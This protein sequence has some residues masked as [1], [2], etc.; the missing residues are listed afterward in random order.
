MEGYQMTS[1]VL[2]R[3]DH[4]KAFRDPCALYQD[5]IWWLYYT[6]V[7]TEEDGRV[8]LYT[9]MS[10]SANLREWSK[11]LLLTPRDQHL[12]FSSPG[13]V[14]RVNNRWRMCLQSYPRPNGEKY[15]NGDCRIWMMESEDLVNWTAPELL[16]VKG[17][18]VADKD[19]GRMIDPYFIENAAKPGEWFCFYKQNGVS[20]SKTDN[21]RQWTYCGNESAGEN[22]CIIRDEG[23]Y[24]MFHSPENGIGVMR[25]YDLVHWRE[26]DS[27]ITLGQQEWEWAKGRITAG[28][29]LDLRHKEGVEAFVMFFHGSG[30]EDERVLF[31]THA[32]IGIAWSRDLKVWDWPGK[33]SK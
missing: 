10:Q 8:Y 7:E 32:S 12:N 13:N 17:D 5:G 33:A 9:A 20:L 24:V 15:G 19:M 30:P 1:P 25:S 22:V 11:P 3:G 4:K 27:L 28:F 18:H 23:E 14:I 6:L 26:E 16:R 2:L 29:V 21:F 31:D